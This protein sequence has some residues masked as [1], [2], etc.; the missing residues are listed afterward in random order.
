MQKAKRPV[1]D[2]KSLVARLEDMYSQRENIIAEQTGQEQPNILSTGDGDADGAYIMGVVL[3]EVAEAKRKGKSM[4]VNDEQIRI[5]QT[6][7][8][9]YG[10]A[11]DDHKQ[12][13][14]KARRE[15]NGLVKGYLNLV[16]GY[17]MNSEIGAKRKEAIDKLEGIARHG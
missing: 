1:S 16:V 9:N 15:T 2:Y 11:Y 8:R 14:E 5:L 7:A 17:K 4:S 10:R 3:A 6:Y 12:D 13:I